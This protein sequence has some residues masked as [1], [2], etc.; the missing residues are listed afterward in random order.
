MNHFPENPRS[1]EFCQEVTRKL[2][3]VQF[4][5]HFQRGKVPFEDGSD[6]YKRDGC[7]RSQSVM[8]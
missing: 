4:L 3:F 2:R 6:R 1:S 5:E 8:K 7:N